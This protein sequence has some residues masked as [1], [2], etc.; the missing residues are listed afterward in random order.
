[1]VEVENDVLFLRKK[2]GREEEKGRLFFK[3][4]RSLGLNVNTC[5][6]CW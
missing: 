5:L 1:M 2:D 6:V 4:I 3:T